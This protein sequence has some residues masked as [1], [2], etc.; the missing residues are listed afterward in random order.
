MP[1]SVS[2]TRP[3][4]TPSCSCVACVRALRATLNRRASS[5]STGSGAIAQS[6]SHGS[7]A[8]MAASAP[9]K[10]STVWIRLMAPKPTRLRTAVTSLEARVMRSPVE[11]RAKN[12]GGNFCS[13]AYRPSRRSAS[14]RC[15][16]PIVA[17]REPSRV[18]Q[19][20][21]A[22]ARIRPTSPPRAAPAPSL[23]SASIACLTVHGIAREKPVAAARQSAPSV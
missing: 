14:T 21:A 20:A 3:D 7:T 5:T 18:I 4:T 13:A 10:A 2:W 1:A 23:A 9:P 6:V 22:S 12:S 16:A 11:W 19:W 15:A 8:S 17:N